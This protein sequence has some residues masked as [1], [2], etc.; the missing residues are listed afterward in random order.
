MSFLGGRFNTSDQGSLLREFLNPQAAGGENGSDNDSPVS[1]QGRG[2]TC[3]GP[4]Q[5]LAALHQLATQ[6]E[7]TLLQLLHLVGEQISVALSVV[8]WLLCGCFVVA[9]WLWLLCG[10]FV[11]A[12]WL[13]CGCFVVA[14]SGNK[15][16]SLQ[17]ERPPELS[18]IEQ[19]SLDPTKQDHIVA[20]MLRTFAQHE[21][22][23]LLLV[24]SIKSGHFAQKGE[25][26]SENRWLQ[27][28]D[29]YLQLMRP[30]CMQC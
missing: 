30:M 19:F 18:H 27:A 13:L 7:V 3:A 14:L 29:R 11:V 21:F 16:S 28:L 22:E 8:L 4:Q 24:W 9:L 1:P 26:I 25:L 6:L 2:H 12:L 20:R 5:V 15:Y 17:V 23:N 10:C